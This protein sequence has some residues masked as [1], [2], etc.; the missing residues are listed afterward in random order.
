M[1]KILK[2]L[3]QFMR[4]FSFP[5]INVSTKKKIFP[6][7]IKTFANH[8]PWDPLTPKK[9]EFV[10]TKLLLV[11]ACIFVLMLKLSRKFIKS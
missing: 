7:E 6:K 1:N 10:K 4:E 8:L 2:V 11:L 9:T 5:L 3:V